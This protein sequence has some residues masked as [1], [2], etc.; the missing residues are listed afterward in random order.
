ME[1]VRRGL[2][3]S[4]ARAQVLVDA[5]RV[6]VAGSLAE[7]AGRLVGPADAV[8]VTGPA[9]R[10]VSRGGQKL[11][12][13]LDRFQVTV[14][15]RQV[16][17]AG[18]STGGFTDCLLQRG[19]AGVVAADVGYGQLHERLRGDPRVRVVERLNIR[20]ARLVQLG[21]RPFEL[22]TADLSFIS[23]RTVAPPLVDLTVL[24]ADLVVLIKPQFE[25]GRRE[26]SRGR[27]VISDPAVWRRAIEEV[28]AAWADAG[29]A[30]M[31]L[32]VS[33]LRGSNGNVEFLAHF[34]RSCPP[35]TLAGAASSATGAGTTESSMDR[36]DTKTL[37]AA[38][39]AGAAAL[40][41]DAE[42]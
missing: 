24:G 41:S 27:G 11:D 14:A 12:A 30:M 8:V 17:D 7:K 31:D 3:D 38:A 42:R 25:A 9:P 6:L 15:G 10:F 2:A 32:M 13:A 28:A 20:H 40:T 22:V 18:A 19:A 36:V 1:L 26:A 35:S 4:R 16:L 34:R 23:L 21:G 39:L 37:V 5:R 33:P 29:A